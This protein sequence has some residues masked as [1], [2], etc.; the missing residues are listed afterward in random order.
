M[1]IAMPGVDGIEAT[2]LLRSLSPAPH[3]LILTSLSPSGT[4]ERAVEAG[5][6]GFVSKTDA[7]DD[8]IRRIHRGMRGRAAV[9]HGQSETAD[10]RSERHAAAFGVAM[11]R[12]PCSTR[13]PTASARP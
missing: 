5:A 12:A 8:I 1:D 11:R 7:A 2:R 4:V 10:R 6:E 3:V 9:Q 13:C